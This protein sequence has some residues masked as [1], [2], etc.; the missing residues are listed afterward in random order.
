MNICFYTDYTISSMTG[1]IGRVTTVLTDYFRNKFGWKVFSIYAFQADKSC[2]LTDTD[3]AIKLRLHDRLGVRNLK[4][5]YQEAAK[6]I[7]A[8]NIQIVIIQTSM[9]VAARLKNVFYKFGLTNVKVISVLHYTPG[10]DE[11]PISTKGFWK[12]ISQRKLSLKDF[13]KTI[14]APIYN[15][16]EHKATVSAYQNAYKYSEQVIV[17]SQSYI[18]LYQKFS[19]LTDDSK[20]KAIPNCVP[21]EYHLSIQELQQKQNSVLVVGRMVDF[22]KRISLIL[23]M[24][25]CIEEQVR[26]WSLEIVGDGPDLETF[27]SLAVH[28]GL[29]RVSFEGRQNP[30]EYYKKA[31]IFL[32]TSEFEGFPMTLVEAQQ[33][34]CVPIAFDSFDS[35][36][37]VVRNGINGIIITNNQSN[38]Y[39]DALLSL[40]RDD[41]YREKMALQATIDCRRYSLDEICNLWKKELEHLVSHQ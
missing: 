1:G 22:P 21:F 28:L 6:F 3:G 13:A 15:I 29:S 32:M 36:K 9:D 30:I 17:L 24:W 25:S 18:P 26:D 14:V 37:E 33:M 11:F 39:I 12:G 31:S 41:V 2:T 35:L 23:D 5:N 10:T 38:R 4:N 20:L 16:W 19:G 27:K 8:N 7:K 40:M 34:G